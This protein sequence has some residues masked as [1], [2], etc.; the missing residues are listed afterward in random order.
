ME[1][2]GTDE[3]LGQAGR[4]GLA[5][6]GGQTRCS[7]A[8]FA[9]VPT[10][11]TFY[12][13]DRCVPPAI[14]RPSLLLWRLLS[15]GEIAILLGWSWGGRKIWIWDFPMTLLDLTHALHH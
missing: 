14:K 3:L 15:E 13:T 4:A 5:P 12:R 11:G 8:S 1:G 2:G 6:V 7:K 9:M 10:K